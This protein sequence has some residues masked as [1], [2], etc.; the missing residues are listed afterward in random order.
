VVVGFD[1]KPIITNNL[2]SSSKEVFIDKP[3]NITTYDDVV[4]VGLLGG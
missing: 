4:V 2:T 1:D 3:S